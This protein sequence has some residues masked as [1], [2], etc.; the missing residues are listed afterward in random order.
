MFKKIFF[1]FIVWL[2]LVN[3]FLFLGI[4]LLP[5]QFNFLGGGL[6]NYLNNPYPY[7]WLNFD[8]E[9][10]LSIAQRGYQPLTHFFFPMYP[11]LIFLLNGLVG[12]SINNLPYIGLLV[13]YVSL[14][15][16]LYG[17]AKIIDLDFAISDRLVLLFAMLLFPTAFYFASFYTESLFLALS[18]WSFYF[19]RKKKWILASFFC[20]L[21][22]AT[23]ITGLALLL[24]LLIE[25]LRSKEKFNVKQF[26]GI[27][28][29][30]LGI[31]G[32]M[33]YLF[34]YFGDPFLFAKNL[35]EVF[36]EQRA[37]I[38]VLFPQIFYRYVFKIIPSLDFDYWPFV[39]TVFLEIFSAVFFILGVF[40]LFI[41]K[42]Y[43]YA[44]YAGFIFL[45]STFS[46][47]FSSLPRYVL[48]AF[49]V[50][51]VYSLYISKVNRRLVYAIYFLFSIFLCISAMLFTRG[52][53]IS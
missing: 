15:F 30:P 22:T 11:L 51:I 48:S 38:F 19:A 53:W 16:A 42:K 52:Y 1:V 4:P 49:P 25:V 18:V 17:L 13:S 34:L 33:L 36:G 44:L 27:L 35:G 39:Y 28:I 7:A 32:Y 47:S 37:G 20:F 2:F 5:L 45:L 31:V 3:S 6:D 14:I 41:Q 9:H 50:F 40:L 23:R 26:L 10:Y 12:G 29:A 43:I 8:G 46:G 21:S 24:V